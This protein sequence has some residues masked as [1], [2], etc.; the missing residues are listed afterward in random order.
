LRPPGNTRLPAER[1]PSVRFVLDHDVPVS[2]RTMLIREGHE[3]WSAGDAGLAVAEDDDLTIYSERQGAV[4]VSLDV[5][6][7]RRR[8]ANAIGRHVRLRCTEPA[9]AAVLRTHL[10]EVLDYLERE[11]VT[12]TVSRDGVKADSDW[13]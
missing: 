8:R 6:F 1:E 3:T 9:A 13:A 2:V 10:K 7:M 11:H 12:V 4:L 5:E